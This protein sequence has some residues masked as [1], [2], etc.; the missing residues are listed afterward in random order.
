MSVAAKKRKHLLAHE[1]ILNPLLSL[2]NSCAECHSKM[3]SGTKLFIPSQP[4]SAFKIHVQEELWA[5]C[6]C[7]LQVENALIDLLHL[8]CISISSNPTLLESL[9]SGKDRRVLLATCAGAVRYYLIT[10]PLSSCRAEIS[11]GTS[12]N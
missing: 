4:I 2:L 3:V 8:L 11:R 7:A 6:F 12:G 1:P 5:Y 9:F 10:V